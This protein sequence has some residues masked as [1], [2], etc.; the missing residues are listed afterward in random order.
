MQAKHASSYSQWVYE[1]PDAVSALEAGIA[2]RWAAMTVLAASKQLVLDDALLR[3]QFK[4]KVELWVGRHVKMAETLTAWSR[5][6]LAYLQA[7]EGI[8]S[9]ADAKYHLSLLESFDKEKVCRFAEYFTL[10]LPCV[11]V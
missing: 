11:I 9:S 7:K 3:E 2:A 5:D 8:S 1:H 4:E 10:F 6:R